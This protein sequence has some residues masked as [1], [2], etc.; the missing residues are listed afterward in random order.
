MKV[1]IRRQISFV[2]VLFMACTIVLSILLNLFFLE[3]YYQKS[4]MDDLAYIYS[5]LN[6]LNDEG[7]LFRGNDPVVDEDLTNSELGLMQMANMYNVEILA[8]NGSTGEMVCTTMLDRF[9]LKSLSA[10]SAVP[11]ENKQNKLRE[12]EEYY[13]MI[14]PDSIT[15]VEY[16]E[17]YGLLNDGSNFIIRT[18]MEGIRASVEI[19]NRFLLNAG[20]VLLFI[21]AIAIYFITKRISDPIKQIALLSEQ[22][23]DMNFDVKYSGKS[24][25]E[26]ALLG[27]NINLLSFAL[28]KNISELKSAN[29]ELRKDIEKK[30]VIDEKRKEF[31]S[32]ISH[33]LKTPIALI[34]GYAEG[35]EENVSDDAESREYYCEVIIDEAKKLNT[36]VAQL[37]NLNQLEE[38]VAPDTFERFDIIDLLKNSLQSMEIL[39]LQKGIHAELVTKGPVFVWGDEFKIEQVVQNYLSNAWNH[40]KNEKSIIVD[41]EE[42]NGLVRVNVFNTGEPIPEQS[43]PYIWDKFYKV[44]KARTRE[45]GGSGIGLSIVKAIMSSIDKGY[46]VE[47]KSNGV[48]FWFELDTK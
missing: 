38:G 10:Y 23:A 31:I 7:N 43:L 46:G 24:K 37:L 44:D 36:I 4:K 13:I 2:F 30:E 17:M 45:Y 33:E 6:E 8:L 18:P 39:L 35:L 47:N 40:C 20:L 41:V 26:I 3:D 15:D 19:A 42:T 32:N 25:N 48:L 22:M 12:T 11:G 21:G 29:N 1:T 16:L 14:N 34:Q 27:K 9:L 5:R 28:E